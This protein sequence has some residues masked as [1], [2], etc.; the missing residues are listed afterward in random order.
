[1]EEKE[2]ADDEMV[3]TKEDGTQDLLKILFY[4]ENEERG[5]TYYFLYYPDRPEEVMVMVSSDGKELRVPSDE[6]M[7]EAEEIFDAYEND[8][9]I[10]EAKK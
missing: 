8:P 1:M 3:V 5:L 7:D 4:S 2:L 10:Q 6:E 9:K